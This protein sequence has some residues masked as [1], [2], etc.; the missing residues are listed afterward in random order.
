MLSPF[1]VQHPFIEMAKYRHQPFMAMAKSDLETE[2][3]KIAH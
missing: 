3:A 1:C 2:A